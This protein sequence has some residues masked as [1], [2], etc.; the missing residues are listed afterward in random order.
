MGELKR[1]GRRAMIDTALKVDY[2][3][4]VSKGSS[5]GADGSGWKIAGASPTI[6]WTRARELRTVI[7]IRTATPNDVPVILDLIRGLAAYER[8]PDAVVATEEDV[9]REGFGER[10]SFYVHIATYHDEPIGFALWFYTYS[11]W[12]GT[13]CLHLEDLFVKPEHRG[14]GAGLALMRTLAK[15]AIDAGCK[16]F[17]WQVLNW[18]EPS[19]SFYESLGAKVMPEWIAVRLD[20]EALTQFAESG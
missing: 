4:H 1:T 9:L 19:I 7:A 16:R 6:T 3:I 11:T 20:G 10:P 12:T 15:T 5:T 8:E 18:N 2:V 14:R 13:R 17:V